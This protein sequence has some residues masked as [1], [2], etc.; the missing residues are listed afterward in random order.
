MRAR[1]ESADTI[2]KLGNLSGRPIRTDSVHE[3]GGECVTGANGIR[4]VD[5]VAS[6]FDVIAASQHVHAEPMLGGWISR[7][8]A[9]SLVLFT[10]VVMVGAQ[11]DRGTIQ[12]A[13]RD[14][15]GV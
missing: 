7:A 9:L 4:D 5:A 3:R 2:G 8:I 12:G 6:G 15:T 13:V 14:Q 10:S 1:D 11:I